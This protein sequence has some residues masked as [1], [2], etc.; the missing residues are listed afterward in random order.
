MLFGLSYGE[1]AFLWLVDVVLLC[2][3]CVGVVLCMRVCG[4]CGVAG[5]RAVC[6]CVV[7]GMLRLWFGSVRRVAYCV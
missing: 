6:V 4:W 7:T 2:C 3:C 1:C 5:T